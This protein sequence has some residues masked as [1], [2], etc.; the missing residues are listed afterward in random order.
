M[1][2]CLLQILFENIP[3]MIKILLTHKRFHDFVVYDAPFWLAE[4]SATHDTC[5]SS[6]FPKVFVGSSRMVKSTLYIVPQT[7]VSFL[8]PVD[9]SKKELLRKCVVCHF[10]R[11]GSENSFVALQAPMWSDI[12]GNVCVSDA[13]T[14]STIYI[15][16]QGAYSAIILFSRFVLHCMFRVVFSIM[17]V[18]SKERYAESKPSR[19]SIS[20][21]FSKFL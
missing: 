9:F 21:A 15:I 12:R 5:T 8:C 11:I 13:Q 6:V 16:S 20:M 18:L 1:F 10:F 14:K 19:V 7:F 3:I 2:K 17:I 4:F